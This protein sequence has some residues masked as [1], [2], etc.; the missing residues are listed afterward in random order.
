MRDRDN[1]ADNAQELAP[2]EEPTEPRAA[3]E[4]VR[5]ARFGVGARATIL[6]GLTMGTAAVVVVAT[7]ISGSHTTVS[8]VGA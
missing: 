5:P 3:G 7:A 6:L 2:T 4:I 8:A 1:R